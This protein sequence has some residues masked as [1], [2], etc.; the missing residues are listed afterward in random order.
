VVCDLASRQEIGA[1]AGTAVA[2][3]RRTILPAD[4]EC[5]W[6]LVPQIGVDGAA[7]DPFVDVTFS[8]G[9]TQFDAAAAGKESVTGVGEQAYREPGN[10][11]VGVLQHGRFFAVGVVLHEAGLG[12]PALAATEDAAALAIAKVV[13]SRI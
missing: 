13:A 9:K 4:R 1:A 7:K 8:G 12:T 3:L 2:S 10:G 11:I 6:S 5:T